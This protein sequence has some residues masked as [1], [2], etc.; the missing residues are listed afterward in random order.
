MADDKAQSQK[1]DDDKR[2]PIHNPAGTWFLIAGC[3][4]ALALM[5]RRMNKGRSL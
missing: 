4:G 2:Q 3:T 1:A 5:L